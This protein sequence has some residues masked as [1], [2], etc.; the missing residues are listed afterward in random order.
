[1]STSADLERHLRLSE[2]MA[3]KAARGSFPGYLKSVIADSRPDPRKFGLLAEPWQWDRAEAIGP[4]IESLCRVPGRPKYRGPLNFWFGYSK[5]HDKTGF[6]ARTFNY[7]LG[8]AR[9]PLT[10]YACAEDRDQAKLIRDAMSR[11]LKLNRWLAARVRVNNFEAHGLDN[12]AKLEILA[13]DS[14]SAQGKTPD[15]VVCDEITHWSSK[16]FFDAMFSAR[17]K[18]PDC[19]FVILTNAGIKGTWQWDL[20]N[21]ARASPR[22]R[23]FEQPERTMLA[24]WMDPA[25][26]AEDR[27]LLIPS[28]ADRLLDN[29]WIDPGE[30][31]GYLMLA[32]CVACHDPH[33]RTLPLP[34]RRVF[35]V[36]DYGEKKD[37]TALGVISG[38]PANDV[39]VNRLDVIQGSPESPV[40]IAAVEAWV[41]DRL[42]ET[43][44][45]V[46]LADPHQM[47]GTLQKFEA[48]CPVVRF[49]YRAGKNNYAMA[50]AFRNAVMTRQARWRP[51]A[52]YLPGAED[53]DL[54]AELAALI[55]KPTVYGYRFDHESGK[56]DDRATVVG[57]G[58]LHLT[59]SLSPDDLGPRTARPAP[60][61][62]PT[63]PQTAPFAVRD[64]S[65]GLW[66]GR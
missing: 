58:T 41:A 52:G 7:V 9:R 36:V 42:A 20:R 17:N 5:G 15:I 12:A 11:E 18:R 30:A 49:E 32:D 25:A 53:A 8:Y 6:V 19:V 62:V 27:K 31:N 29:R 24:S 22:W 3:D 66:G 35:F 64:H 46:L 43:P 34:G 2:Q 59:Q 38:G 45:G 14:D 56:H 57:M 44:W 47:V 48:R 16:E 51:G 33:V 63:P 1:M 23:F 10:L 50:Q 40:P 60:V 61:L 37:R 54:D 21:L 26:V 4:A 55:T 28:E 65:R 13:S 39:E